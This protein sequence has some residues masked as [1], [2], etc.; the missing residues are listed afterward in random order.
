MA[1]E[2]DRTWRDQHHDR[3]VLV[4][5][6]TQ[7]MVILQGQRAIFEAALLTEEDDAAVSVLPASAASIESIRTIAPATEAECSVCLDRFDDA[8]KEMPCGHQFHARCI[9][10]WLG[11]HGSCPLCRYRMPGIEARKLHGANG[12]WVAISLGR[13]I[14]DRQRH[15]GGLSPSGD[16][17]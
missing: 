9:E 8:A 5:M 1:V 17:I 13:E 2:Q 3:I 15:H 16:V 7:A 4:N 14:V 11:L 12:V 10:R 6:T